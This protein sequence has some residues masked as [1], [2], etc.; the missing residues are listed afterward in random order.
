MHLEG[1]CNCEGVHY[2]YDGEPDVVG[3]CHCKACQRQA[4]GSG[5]I[6]VCVDDDDLKIVGDTIKK[7][8]TRAD[9]GLDV[10][11]FFCGRCG[12]PIV[13]RC[14][15][16]PGKAFIKAGTLN[17]TSMLKPTV[18]VW[19]EEAQPWMPQISGVERFERGPG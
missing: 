13:S 11:R 2:H 1:Q 19:C 4:G 3:F 15:G 9:S 10:N 18:E 12:S 7:Y 6:F 17:D 16:F 5:S 8:I 14:V